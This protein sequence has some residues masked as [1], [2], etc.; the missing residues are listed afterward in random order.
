[1]LSVGGLSLRPS[2]FAQAYRT[3]TGQ[4]NGTSVRQTQIATKLASILHQST[5]R[6]A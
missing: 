1:L 6:L 2:R 4:P 5:I 3:R